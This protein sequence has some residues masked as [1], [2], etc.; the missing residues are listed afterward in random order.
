MRYQFVK[1]L[2]QFFIRQ[3]YRNPNAVKN[4]KIKIKNE[5]KSK[6]KKLKP[7]ANSTPK[8]QTRRGTH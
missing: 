4:T 5:L 3:E 2:K 7:Q 6:E 8:T 1:W